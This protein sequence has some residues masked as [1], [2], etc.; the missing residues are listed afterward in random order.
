MQQAGNYSFS[1]GI[2]MALPVV[3]GYIP[4][5]FTFGIIAR[6][7]GLNLFQTVLMSLLVFAGAAQ[8]IAVSM[9]G[10]AQPILAIVAV[11]F[12][13]NLRHLLYSAAMS[14]YL[15]HL[16]LLKRFLFG[17]ELSDS[18]FALHSAQFTKE[19]PA[20]SHLF[21]VNLTVHMAWSLGPIL[22]YLAIGLISNVHALGIDF[23]L[24]AVCVFLA[25]KQINSRWTLFIG[26]RAATIAVVASSFGLQNWEI[27]LAI[28][29]AAT[30]GLGGELW[31]QRRSS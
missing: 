2:K 17:V 18:T 11:T 5:S 10:S 15:R 4:V 31:K 22:G 7:V 24:P 26:C 14:T 12:I 3:I 6:E 16:P 8:F 9:L 19:V 29:C 1:T 23:A 27:I 13:V 28:V 20:L 21:G 25:L 30:V